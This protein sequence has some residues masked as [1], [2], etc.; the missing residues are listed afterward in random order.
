VNGLG[1][2][3]SNLQVGLVAEMI[4]FGRVQPL[5]ERLGFGILG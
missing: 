3:T 1:L 5:S 4:R 2:G